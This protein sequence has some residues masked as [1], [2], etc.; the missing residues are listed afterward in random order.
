MF[1]SD[2]LGVDWK[3]VTPAADGKPRIVVDDIDEGGEADRQGSG[4]RKGMILMSI[5][6]EDINQSTATKAIKKQ[7][8]QAERPLKCT[9]MVDP[10]VDDEIANQH[11]KG[12]AE[13][14]VE[15]Q[16]IGKANGGDK[17][18]PRPIDVAGQFDA[19]SPRWGD[20]W[21]GWMPTEEFI[22]SMQATEV[23]PPFNCSESQ[24]ES[25][26]RNYPSAIA[27]Q[28]R[29]IVLWWSR[30]ANPVRSAVGH[31]GRL[32]DADDILARPAARCQDG[33]PNAARGAQ[34][35]GAPTFHTPASP[36]GVPADSPPT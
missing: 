21:D 14:I 13:V 4:L 6:G 33:Q 15:L 34:H 25:L 28:A 19:F 10:D 24:L 16:R 8:Q 1:D 23:K 2:A 35:G 30:A 3:S 26:V 36:P 29:L 20:E 11:R 27:A 18:D 9:F 32:N 7:L 5:A 17:K 22:A 12:V 31:G